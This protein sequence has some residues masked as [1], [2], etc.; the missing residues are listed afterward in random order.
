MIDGI[1][2]GAPRLSEPDI[3]R[4][5]SAADV[6][7]GSF[8]HDLA[9]FIPVES[10]MNQRPYEA[11]A[12]RRAH[13]DC[14]GTRD[15]GGIRSAGV[16]FVG[17][18]QKCS[19]IARGGKTEPEHQ[20]V[21]CPVRQ[22]IKPAGL[23]AGR[24]A[25]PDI[26]DHDRLIILARSE[27]P[28]RIRNQ[29]ARLVLA[30]ADGQRRQETVGERFPVVGVDGRIRLAGDRE[31]AALQRQRC[32]RAQRGQFIAHRPGD[33]RAVGSGCD[34]DLHRHAIVAGNHVR[35]PAEPDQR[36]TL[37]L[38]EA[39]AGFGHRVDVAD[40][41]RS[42][43]NVG[44]EQH[45][46]ALVAAVEDVEEQH[47]IGLRAIGRPQNFDI[48]RIFD[49]APGVL[50]RSGEVLDHGI[51]RR[52]RVDFAV[53]L[54]NHALV[55]AGRAKAAATEGRRGLGNFQTHNSCLRRNRPDR[56]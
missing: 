46:A 32:R 30:D 14:L 49:H 19:E 16:V 48:G 12:L 28:I 38:H 50:R 41:D 33:R 54:A 10:E 11:A 4:Y 20:R 13:H 45:K 35:L 6:R 52:L 7:Q 18:F 22:F 40:I 17:C 21:F 34:R 42:A 29:G 8:E 47:T 53:S 55:G 1:V 23:E 27:R 9:L 56:Y 37:L 3:E 44:V 51:G 31:P 25:N 39:I 36:V 2:C 26:A 15:I 24:I 43:G 5:Q